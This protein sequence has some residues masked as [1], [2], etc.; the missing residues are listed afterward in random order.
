MIQK[1]STLI[2]DVNET[3][4]DLGPLK[5]SIDAALGNGAA[6]VWFAELLHYSLVESITGSYQDF[7]A[8]AA[9]VLKMN[10]LKNKKD[11]SR[12]RVSDILSPITRLQPYPDVKQGLRKLTNGGFKLVAFSNGKPSVLE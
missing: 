6:E 5:D 9:A 12:E 10:A 4:L 7:S 3:L 2:F 1:I 11:P 8:I